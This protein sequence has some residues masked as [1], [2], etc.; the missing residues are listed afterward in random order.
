[1][2]K[3]L[4]C[5]VAITCL[6]WDAIAQRLQ[7][8]ET[9]AKSE[10]REANG[11]KVGRWTYRWPN[12]KKRAEGE[13]VAGKIHGAWIVYDDRGIKRELR[14]FDSGGRDGTWQ[15]FHEAGWV[16]T[17]VRWTHGILEGPR[18]EWRWD[19]KKEQRYKYQEGNLRDGRQDGV[20]TTFH[21]NGRVES[22]GPFEKGRRHGEF[23]FFNEQGYLTS[24]GRMEYGEIEGVWTFWK[25]GE[26][27]GVFQS[28]RTTYKN[29]LKK[30]PC[31]RFFANGAKE[32]EGRYSNDK[33]SGKWTIYYESGKVRQYGSFK[34]GEYTGV[35]RNYTP[36]GRLESE[37]VTV[38][39]RKHGL[40]TMFQISNPGGK[41]VPKE[42][43]SFI[44]GYRHGHWREFAL[45]GSLA[46]VGDYYLDQPHGVWNGFHPNGQRKARTKYEYGV[47]I[48]TW[49]AWHEDGTRKNT[50][51][52]K[53]GLLDGRR[54]NWYRNGKQELAGSYSK[55]RPEGEWS[56]W[57]ESGNL[58]ASG[59]LAN[60]LATGRWTY[61]HKN[62]RKLATGLFE[63]NRKTGDWSYWLPDG[64]IDTESTG[65]YFKNKLVKR[66]HTV[67]PPP[68]IDLVIGPV[69]RRSIESRL[70]LALCASI[71]ERARIQRLWDSDKWQ[72]VIV[73]AKEEIAKHKRDHRWH[74][75]NYL[76]ILELAKNRGEARAAATKSIAVLGSSP[77]ELVRFVDKALFAD[78][79]V[80]EYQMALMALTPIAKAGRSIAEV[81]IAHLRALDGCGNTMQAVSSS[82]RL[83][84]E[85][86][87]ATEDLLGVA[88]AICDLRFGVPL[89]DVALAAINA[90]VKDWP[91]SE[92]VM[93]VRY[94]V[95][96]DLQRDRDGARALGK[97]IIG[98]LGPANL[99]GWVWKLLTERPLAG[100]YHR[101]A[102]V[103]AERMVERGNLQGFECDTVALAKFLNGRIDEAIEYQRRA[104]KLSPNDSRLLPKLK[105][106]LAEKA[107][108]EQKIKPKSKR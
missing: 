30:G 45:D 95:L 48:G 52:Y 99:N 49:N 33:Q 67:E 37:G 34:D 85:L 63:E 41:P 68:S 65:L 7:D 26:N 18:T 76:A 22:R 19:H 14:Q 36:D 58:R 42:I 62:G 92:Y 81:R 102:L 87:A 61:H 12:G 75:L 66:K 3:A 50:M 43:G 105:I 32:S 107:T 108:R 55:G 10:G 13:Y 16:Q 97:R 21:S 39:G 86:G 89:G 106:Y 8:F 57:F 93:R 71:D 5:A 23:R 94:R 51:T 72:D 77:L 24:E 4:I 28:E 59:S 82:E 101:L 100:R 90:Y 88:E 96:R 2:V 40:W 35:W 54:E 98:G 79:T 80:N 31:V 69:E 53:L 15:L 104:I 78:P 64:S 56:Y 25:K 20:C 60:G 103:G 91:E 84:E 11:K 38:K 17:R 44:E 70:G 27:G 74:A 6:S 47:K 9:A 83:I 73:V 1:L 46:E 29:S